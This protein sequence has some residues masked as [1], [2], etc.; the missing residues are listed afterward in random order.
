MAVLRHRRL[1]RANDR[2]RDR[3]DPR[4]SGDAGRS[5]GADRLRRRHGCRS[6]AQH[7]AGRG[8]LRGRRRRLRRC[9]PLGDHGRSA[10]GCDADHRD[11]LEPGQARARPR[12]RR[13]PRS[14]GRR[15][16]AG[17]RRDLS[18]RRARLR[19][20]GRRCAGDAPPRAEPR[21][22][23]RHAHAG[24]HG[25]E[26]RGVRDRAV[27]VRRRRAHAEGIDAT[28]RPSPSGTS[29]G[30]PGCTSRGG[31]RSTA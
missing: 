23:R 5:G 27:R 6:G 25:G 1:L 3:R 10:L 20:R 30:S 18:G 12:A 28:A 16:R 21:A 14:A 24:R 8:R 4:A 29:R 7:R 22:S 11:R 15:C 9:R 31:C 2:A 26:G 13:D 19:V 17:R